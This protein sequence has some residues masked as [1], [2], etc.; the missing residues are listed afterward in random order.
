MGIETADALFVQVIYSHNSRKTE[1]RIVPPIW[2]FGLPELKMEMSKEGLLGTSVLLE[3]N[4]I[5]Q[6]IEENWS[7]DD[8]TD[9]CYGKST[10]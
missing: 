7:G 5:F 9:N 6:D 8:A 10:A 4:S 3:A 1:N 2:A